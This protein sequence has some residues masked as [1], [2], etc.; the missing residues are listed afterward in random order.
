MLANLMAA[1]GAIPTLPTP[2]TVTCTPQRR[3][4]LSPAAAT[5]DNA[6]D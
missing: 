3:L 2:P 4:L 1:A 6:L 5:R